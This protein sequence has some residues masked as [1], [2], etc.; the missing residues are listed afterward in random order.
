MMPTT[1]QI[2]HTTVISFGLAAQGTK[3]TLDSSE[4]NS[5]FIPSTDTLLLSSQPINSQVAAR[6]ELT[7]ISTALMEQ[8]TLPRSQ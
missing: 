4:S 5:T 7:L 8:L 6:K 2:V 3:T 1:P